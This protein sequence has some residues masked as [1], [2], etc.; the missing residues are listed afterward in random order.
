MR[1][2]LVGLEF[3]EGFS[4]RCIWIL[5]VVFT[6]TGCGGSS[7]GSGDTTGRPT[8]PDQ[9]TPSDPNG[10]YKPLEPSYSGE[11]SDY[12]ISR[13][14][15]TETTLEVLFS[16]DFINALLFA[17]SHQNSFFISQTNQTS[18]FDD[19]D[20]SCDSGEATTTVDQLLR[21]VEIIYDKCV[22]QGELIDGAVY[23]ELN[24]SGRYIVN[25]DLAIEDLQSF[26]VVK[27]EGHYIRQNENLYT[28]KLVAEDEQN[29]QV[30]L[31]DFTIHVN[32]S[33]GSGL[34]YTGD[35][36]WSQGG[37]LRVETTG[38][39]YQFSSSP[40]PVELDITGDGSLQLEVYP[41]TTATIL[42][43]DEDSSLVLPLANAYNF[44]LDPVE[45]D[46]VVAT[47]NN[48]PYEQVFSLDASNSSDKNIEYLSFS[49]RAIDQ[50]VGS[51]V[52]FTDA[53]SATTEVSFD[54]P[55]DY[56]LELVVTD[57][58]GL[59][60]TELIT[61]SVLT[62]PPEGSIDF[63]GDV[64]NLGQSISGKVVVDNPEF[65]GPYEY[66][67]AYGP[68]DLELNSLGELSWNGLLPNLNQPLTINFGVYVTSPSHRSLLTGSVEVAPSEKPTI[69][70][71]I[72]MLTEDTVLTYKDGKL[73]AFDDRFVTEVII[74]QGQVSFGPA[75]E[76]S[77]F[78]NFAYTL[79]AVSDVNGDSVDDFWFVYKELEN[80]RDYAAR[81][82]LIDGKSGD[83]LKTINTKRVGLEQ[84]NARISFS[85]YDFDGVAEL[86]LTSKKGSPFFIDVYDIEK[87]TRIASRNYSVDTGFT[88][89]Y[90]DD[91]LAEVAIS[92]NGSLELYDLQTSTFN[93][94]IFT[95]LPLNASFEPLSKS[96]EPQS[97]YFLGTPSINSNKNS[98]DFIYLYD[99]KEDSFVKL[100]NIN[101]FKGNEQTFS[102][103]I[104]RVVDIDDDS[105]SEILVSFN[106]Q[107]DSGQAQT[108]L[109][110]EP[111]S[112]LPTI[113]LVAD[114]PLLT[115]S[116]PI[117][118]DL[119]QDGKKEVIFSPEVTRT[120]GPYVGSYSTNGN[121]IFSFQD[122]TLTEVLTAKPATL[123][124]YD[125]NKWTSDNLISVTNGYDS[126]V[127]G[128]PSGDYQ[129]T[130]L[131]GSSVAT[132][133]QGQTVV[134]MFEN[135]GF[136]NATT[137]RKLDANNNQLWVSKKLPNR[138]SS[139]YAM[140]NE[141]LIA[142][143]EEGFVRFLDT[144]TGEVVF[145]FN[146]KGFL[147][148]ENSNHLNSLVK[149]EKQVFV[150]I[151][152]SLSVENTVM[153]EVDSDLNF[154]VISNEDTAEFFADVSTSTDFALLQIDNDIQPELVWASQ[155]AGQDYSVNALDLTSYSLNIVDESKLDL[156]NIG[157][158]RYSANERSALSCLTWDIRC[159]NFF[160]P[161]DDYEIAQKNRIN[162][163]VVWA[164]NTPKDTEILV[165][166]RRV[167]DRIVYIGRKN[168]LDKYSY[169]LIE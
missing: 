43:N 65:D 53:N 70:P 102:S 146:G 22:E 19:E 107:Q 141:K 97:C 27:I 18:T 63:N 100:I 10:L 136:E 16:L 163:N 37:K 87:E 47:D 98:D 31:D 34:A 91:G 104:T 5:V 33:L 45:P 109:I 60:T 105:E 135:E 147:L 94:P 17:D 84:N 80:D 66:Q 78:P 122:N 143:D 82:I 127:V 23:A 46:L 149:T 165:D 58:T 42:L 49:W 35:I 61:I 92:A 133:E 48:L 55:G 162:R 158:L 123:A 1:V 106:F 155:Q 44:P 24:L 26:E 64:F 142:L 21:R 69:T 85:D 144:N 160:E 138:Y 119:N 20:I 79:E 59:S 168:K 54:T 153:I 7:S 150:I 89:D 96:D 152:S 4:M 125:L 77:F 114:K 39:I 30:F 164:A 95:G 71:L 132:I 28:L 156:S 76:P 75:Q 11:Q 151:Q 8:T 57:P 51:N 148:N 108:Y 67:I 81:I 14:N 40:R 116:N 111:F 83:T 99:A 112:D 137:I 62:R 56:T 6:I 110:N 74:D 15:A 52:S 36:Y 124:P 117:I 115:D 131:T 72:T 2:Y 86:V 90:N 140:F 101:N 159:L 166:S 32:S 167:G 118:Y 129:N 121:I 38:L 128:G 139:Y 68:N 154:S 9:I 3:E 13:E 41:K 169:Y 103:I 12:T 93:S 145:D 113:S 120:E 161:H 88:C 29:D 73:L 50:S 25:F 130:Y 157:V 134:Y 126:H